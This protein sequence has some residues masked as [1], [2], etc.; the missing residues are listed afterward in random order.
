VYGPGIPPPFPRFSPLT[1]P[2][3]TT[4]TLHLPLPVI[5]PALGTLL[6]LINFG[7]TWHA[8]S[9]PSDKIAARP[10]RSGLP[11]IIVLVF[12]TMLLALSG[13]KLHPAACEFHDKWQGMFQ[14]HDMT[15]AKIQN[16]FSCCGFKKPHDMPFPFPAKGI[17]VTTCE[18]QTGRN[19]G[20]ADA[21][22]KQEGLSMAFLF[23]VG[24]VLVVWKVCFVVLS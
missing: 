23:A 6:P 2:R 22:E 3:V 17:N 20:C 16:K 4:E 7:G 14:T 9:Q 15:I 8:L 24:G 13:S 1:Y 18:V 11:A 21:W 12:D 19:I 5:L 10:L